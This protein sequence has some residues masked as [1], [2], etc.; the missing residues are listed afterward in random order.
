MDIFRNIMACIDRAKVFE[1]ISEYFRE[2]GFRACCYIVPSGRDDGALDLSDFGFPEEWL[3]RYVADGL[4]RHDPNPR[5][6][7]S[8][9][10]VFW[11]N[12][13]PRITKMDRNEQNFYRELSHSSMTDG[14][15]LPTYGLN[16]RFGYFGA[17]MIVNQQVK[18]QANEALLLAVAQA[19]HT[20]L[21]QLA[22]DDNDFKRLSLRERQILHWIAAGKSNYEI[23]MILGISS[24]TVAT[25]NKRL[26]D[27]LQVNDRVAASTMAIKLGLV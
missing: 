26:F 10:K 20:R 2:K 24:A 16:Q 5:F 15:A 3:R 12:D 23:G 21:D 6:A 19:A 8:H 7:M 27:K 4:G 11:W 14:I 25:Y 9:G 17:G 22:A 18:E 13:L 1:A